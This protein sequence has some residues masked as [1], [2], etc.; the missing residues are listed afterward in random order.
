MR[1][2]GLLSATPARRPL[3]NLLAKTQWAALH[4][5][6]PCQKVNQIKAG[7]F[8]TALAARP[9]AR[10]LLILRHQGC[11]RPGCAHQDISPSSPDNQS[12]S[13]SAPSYH[14]AVRLSI[15][16]IC[17]HLSSQAT[18]SLSRALAAQPRPLPVRG[19]G[20]SANRPRPSGTDPKGASQ[21]YPWNYLGGWSSRCWTTRTP[22]AWC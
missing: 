21:S 16:F 5:A 14:K 13:L 8:G 1:G 3:A 15:S 11:P 22:A 17:F 12:F 2:R 4:R 9:P 6:P 7:L 18:K 20:G 10:E 19:C